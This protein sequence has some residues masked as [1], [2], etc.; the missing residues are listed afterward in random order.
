MAI[1]LIH[2]KGFFSEPAY[3]F[4]H[5]LKQQAAYSSRVSELAPCRRRRG[6]QRR[7]APAA[8]RSNRRSTSASLVRP[9]C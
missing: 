6:V 2:E 4:Q 5:L 9:K 3:M 8:Y 1:E 7:A